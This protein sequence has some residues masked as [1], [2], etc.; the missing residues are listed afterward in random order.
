MQHGIK[1]EPEARLV[2]TQTTNYN[3]KETGLIVSKSH[4]WL[5]Y[6]PD[7]IILDGNNNPLKLLEIKCLF[8]GNMLIFSLFA[9]YRT[10]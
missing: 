1:T 5:A 8:I 3:V 6:S 7:G 4:P 2:Y 9:N 10:L